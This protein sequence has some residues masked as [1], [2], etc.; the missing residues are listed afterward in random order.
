MTII[1]NK[2]IDIED[3]VRLALSSTLKVY[4]YI[5]GA[6]LKSVVYSQIPF[7]PSLSAPDKNVLQ[8]ET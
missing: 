7:A 4:V 5:S 8:S 1:I 2:S 6:T 3:E